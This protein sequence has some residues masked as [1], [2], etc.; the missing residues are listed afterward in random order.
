MIFKS[1]VIKVK[2]KKNITEK[3]ALFYDINVGIKFAFTMA[4][5]HPQE[6]KCQNKLIKSQTKKKKKTVGLILPQ[7]MRQ[8]LIILV[9]NLLRWFNLF[10]Q[11]SL[12]AC[13]APRCWN[14]LNWM[15]R[16]GSRC[17]TVLP[18]MQSKGWLQLYST[19]N[20]KQKQISPSVWTQAGRSSE[21]KLHHRSSELIRKEAVVVNVSVCCDGRF[22]GF[23][24][25]LS[26]W[27]C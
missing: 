23:R 15:N 9:I 27:S 11:L 19:T 8:G 21:P 6:H 24:S 17:F 12:E 1:A 20:H 10:K 22:R 16:S 13:S 18:D 5:F 2:K 3:N 26:V 4:N 14:Q 25:H 7:K